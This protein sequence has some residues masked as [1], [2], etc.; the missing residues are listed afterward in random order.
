[1][2]MSPKIKERFEITGWT[3]A[4]S[5]L[6]VII[7]F[8]VKINDKIDYSYESNV[9]QKETNINVKDAINDLRKHD[10]VLDTRQDFLSERFYTLEGK[11]NAHHR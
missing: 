6:G 1:M 8:L 9:T 7:W 10:A 4:L 11:V 2:R 3:I 5:L